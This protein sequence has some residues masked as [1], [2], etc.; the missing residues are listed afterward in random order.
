MNKKTD[1]SGVSVDHLKI[2]SAVEHYISCG[3][4]IHVV[5]EGQ[6]REPVH[7]T[8]PACAADCESEMDTKLELLKGLVAKGAGVSALQYSLRMNRKD[9]KRLASENGLKIRYSRPVRR[10]RSARSREATTVDDVVAGHAMHYS[11]LGYTVPEIAQLLGLG[12][13]DV[14]D[15]GQAYRFEFNKNREHAEIARGAPEDKT[16]CD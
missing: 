9:I 11:T 8:G 12:V 6:T 7:P 10:T 5:P 16:D 3:G 14:W 13:R 15:I 4:V 2:A 1:P